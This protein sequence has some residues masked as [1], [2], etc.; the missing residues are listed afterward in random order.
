LK[1]FKLWQKRI[2][3]CFIDLNIIKEWVWIAMEIILEAR[4]MKTEVRGKKIDD[5]GFT[6]YDLRFTNNE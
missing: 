1:V 4:N 6:I 3:N 2:C 5:L